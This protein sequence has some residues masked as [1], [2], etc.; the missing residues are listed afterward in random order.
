MLD[1]TAHPTDRNN[2]ACCGMNVWKTKLPPTHCAIDERIRGNN[3]NHL[4]FQIGKGIVGELLTERYTRGNFFF[5]HLGGPG[6]C[7]PYG[8]E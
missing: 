2:I 5:Q 4:F 1:I 6:R 3:D 7:I 8:Q